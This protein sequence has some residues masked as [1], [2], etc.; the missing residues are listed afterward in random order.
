MKEVLDELKSLIKAEQFVVTGSYALQELGLYDK[1]VKDLDVLIYKPDEVSLE[2]LER[3]KT[4]EH[5]DDYP[6]SKVHFKC[7]LRDTDIDIW[8][9]DKLQSTI[10]LSNGLS[11]AKP[12][13][14][15][16]AKVGYLRLKDVV[17]LKYIASN[18][19]PDELVNKLLARQMN[20]L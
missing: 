11:L 15:A 20:R 10:T 1:K 5:N 2:V 3:L 14:I 12:F 9:T 18:I 19:Y 7:R 13:E 17:Q 4:K 8:I 16:K 6:D